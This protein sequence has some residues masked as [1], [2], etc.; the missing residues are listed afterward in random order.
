MPAPALAELTEAPSFLDGP[1]ENPAAAALSE[2]EERSWYGQPSLRATDTPHASDITRGAQLVDERQAG[3]RVAGNADGVSEDRD[4]VFDTALNASMEPSL[5]GALQSDALSVNGASLAI[6]E[7]E[8]PATEAALASENLA[9]RSTAKSRA[10]PRTTH[11]GIIRE[12]DRVAFAGSE[13]GADP[14]LVSPSGMATV[15]LASSADRASEALVDNRASTQA[16]LPFAN[17]ADGTIQLRLGD[18]IALLEDRMERPL[19]VWLSSAESASKYVTFDTL[20]AAGIGVDYDP[21]RNHVVLS[22]PEE[23]GK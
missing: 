16:T 13:S 10:Q 20:R 4:E 8:S 5:T 14:D 17:S 3:A 7:E 23:E 22:V 12:D 21:V 6:A 2:S 15:S 19:F 11:A 9:L 18:L 1:V